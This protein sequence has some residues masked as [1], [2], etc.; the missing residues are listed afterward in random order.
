MDTNKKLVAA[1][2]LVA[3]GLLLYPPLKIC[4]GGEY[5]RCINTDNDFIW[6]MGPAEKIDFTRLAIYGLAVA[7][8]GGLVYFL[9]KK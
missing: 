6:A 2:A 8:A 9:R 7:I 5:P 4:S 1:F 3:I